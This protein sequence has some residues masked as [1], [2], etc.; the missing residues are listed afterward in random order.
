MTILL[1]AEIFNKLSAVT[2]E[3]QAILHGQSSIDRALYMSGEN[4]II[5]SQKLLE[6]GRLITIRPHTRFIDFP[7]H[8]HDYVEVVYMC[9]GSTTHI[10]NGNE[11]TLYQGELLFLSPGAAHSIKKAAEKDIAVN[12]IILPSFFD[13][14][15]VML[16]EE[17]TPLRRFILNCL[18]KKVSSGSYLHFKV[19][20]ILP[21][22]NLIENLLYTLISDIP[23]KRQINQTT[24]GLLLL[25]LLGYTDRLHVENETDAVLIEVFRYIEDHYRTGRLSELAEFLHYDLYWL[26]REIKRKTGKNY[27]ELLQ[28]KRLSQAAYL[29]R[30]TEIN[31]SDISDA[32][33]YENVSYFHRLFAA[34][35]G[36]SPKKYRNSKIG[37]SYGNA[38]VPSEKTHV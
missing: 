3:E 37:K 22:Q 33:G 2:S 36:M 30:T 31:I 20:D 38:N 5:N 18:S 25:H 10:I 9:S 32:V 4:N 6:M 1:N 24:M 8:T 21:I 11:L 19:T 34:R 16:G 17:E 12:F 7:E 26:S 15:L 35:F 27:T 14:A 23:N 29:L 13:Q 28:E